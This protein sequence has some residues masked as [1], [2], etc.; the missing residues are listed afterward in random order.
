MSLTRAETKA[1]ALSTM[2]RGVF[3]RTDVAHVLGVYAALFF[4]Q[5]W[6]HQVDKDKE[7][8]DGDT[9]KDGGWVWKTRDEWY[10]ETALTYNQQETART[11]LKEN[12][13]LS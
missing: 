8:G 3:L 13:L 7:L 10:E 5:L 1:V 9:T 2:K 12:D 4:S 11:I 6:F